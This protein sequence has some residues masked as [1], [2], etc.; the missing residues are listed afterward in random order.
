MQIHLKSFSNAN[1]GRSCLE[2]CLNQTGRC[3]C[4]SRNTTPSL[5]SNPKLVTLVAMTVLERL[6]RPAV[7]SEDR[8]LTTPLSFCP[9]QGWA[10][11]SVT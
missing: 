1:S 2:T 10:I 6:P 4:S 11:A 3:N 8:C 7:H 9:A 5:P